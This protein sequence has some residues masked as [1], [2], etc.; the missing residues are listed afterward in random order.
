MAE[1]GLLSNS[2]P[3]TNQPT[4]S[5]SPAIQAAKRRHTA[6]F[7]S[8]GSAVPE[9]GIKR[10]KTLKTYGGNRRPVETA[11]DAD[12]DQFRDD[13][14]AG[15]PTSQSARFSEH[16][17]HQSSMPLPAGSLQTDFLNHEPAIMFKDTG[18]TVA[19]AS[20]E[21]QRLYEEVLASKKGVST[22]LTK[23]AQQVSQHQKIGR[24]HV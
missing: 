13:D 9:K 6:A 3:A 12:F 2:A 14:A 15:G 5:E 4:S 19:D 8:E 16:S 23:E 18:D 11:D 22:S 20:S 17:G 24:A 10:S 7:A 21:Q 1:R